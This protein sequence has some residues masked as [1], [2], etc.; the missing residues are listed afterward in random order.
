M[1]LDCDAGCSRIQ[2]SDFPEPS[3][4][5]IEDCDAG[6][7]RIQCSD[8]PE[9]SR[10]LVEDCDAGACS[11]I[12]CSDFPEPSRQLAEDCDAGCSRIQCSD[13]PEPSRG[14][15][16]R[17][18]IRPAEL[19]VLKAE[20]RLA[21]ERRDPGGS[22]SEVGHLPE[23]PIESAGIEYVKLLEKQLAGALEDVRAQR[24][25]LNRLEELRGQRDRS[26][27]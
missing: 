1:P 24:D 7:S 15:E 11:R 12:Q 23:V 18:D 19:A 10:K 17:P 3:R 13:F 26:D 27:A 5:L 6:C 22:G 21:L 16:L 9:P 2:C 20:L 8:F 4:K 14:L 25:S